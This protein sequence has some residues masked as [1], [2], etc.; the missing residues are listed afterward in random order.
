MM[1]VRRKNERQGGMD[2]AVIKGVEEEGEGR[3][4]ESR[5]AAS[6]NCWK[7]EERVELELEVEV[8]VEVEN[9]KRVKGK[10]QGQS[11]LSE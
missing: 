7:E 1:D 2:E 11:G 6:R 10:A 8:E 3:E 5:K 4:G 9:I